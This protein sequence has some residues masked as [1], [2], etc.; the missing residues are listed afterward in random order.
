MSVLVN[1]SKLV[2]LVFFIMCSNVERKC[3]GVTSYNV[4]GGG[5]GGG[6]LDHGY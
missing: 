4:G 6:K 1:V 2:E 5:G 3:T